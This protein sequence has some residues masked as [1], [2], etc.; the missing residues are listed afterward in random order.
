[1][2]FCI[3]RT[4]LQPLSA[5]ETLTVPHAFC[6][7]W[8]MS[9]GDKSWP[10]EHAALTSDRFGRGVPWRWQGMMWWN[11]SEQAAAEAR[12]A[13]GASCTALLTPR[14]PYFIGS[15]AWNQAVS[16]SLKLMLIMRPSTDFRMHMVLD[17]TGSG[18]MAEPGWR[19][20]CFRWRA[21]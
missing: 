8:A 7:R 21:V 14:P 19:D 20:G 5:T 18:G 2:R 4:L 16:S 10:W 3:G 1:M 6:N 11:K 12:K 15:E 17:W 13:E 9:A